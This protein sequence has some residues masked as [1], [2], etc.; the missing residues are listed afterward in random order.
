LRRYSP[1][2]E[3][4]SIDEG[5]LGLNGLRGLWRRG[6][7]AIADHL[8]EAVRAEIGITVSTGISVT[9]TLAK[10]ASDLRKPDGTTIVPGRR[11]AE[12]LSS[13]ALEAIPGVG[14]NR[15]ALLH[16]FRLRTALEFAQAP[17]ALIRRLLGKTGVD[18]RHELR[19]EPV[20]PL[21]LIPKL[22]KSIART[23]SLSEVSE[24]RELLLSHLLYRSGTRYRACGVILTHIRSAVEHTS[25]L[26]GV[27]ERDA[28]QG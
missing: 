9:K 24:N 1:E 7:G 23:A 6:F 11:I 28:R 27:M 25:D 26:F 5:F 4:Y 15:A 3:V 20:F 13:L 19:G 16:K 12:M 2:V 10:I 22:P 8:R 17:E 18:L 14:A 21:E